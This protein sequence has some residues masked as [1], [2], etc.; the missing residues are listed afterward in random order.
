[1]NASLLILKSKKQGSVVLLRNKPERLVRKWYPMYFKHTLTSMRK[2]DPGSPM[3]A[4]K[5]QA[6]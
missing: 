3:L 6:K 1:M 4:G 2:T 5:S